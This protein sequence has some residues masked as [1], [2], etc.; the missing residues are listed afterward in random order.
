MVSPSN[1]LKNG[2]V[3]FKERSSLLPRLKRAGGYSD[4]DYRKKVAGS[5]GIVG[6]PPSFRVEVRTGVHPA[7][8]SAVRDLPE[9]VAAGHSKKQNG[10]HDILQSD[11]LNGGKKGPQ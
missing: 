2:L 1:G 6:C 3:W 9:A 8:K 7:L 4:T 11:S 5:N 10:Q